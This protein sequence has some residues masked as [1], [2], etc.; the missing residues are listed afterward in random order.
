MFTISG[1][2]NTMEDSLANPSTMNQVIANK[3]TESE[4]ILG[5]P[6]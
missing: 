2:A 1:V 4:Y 6:K 5:S 3:C